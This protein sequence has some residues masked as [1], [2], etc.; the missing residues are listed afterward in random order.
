MNGWDEGGMRV[1]MAAG[2]MAM[3]GMQ[4][5]PRQVSVRV[6]QQHR[7]AHVSEWYRY[8]AQAVRVS[9][10]ATRE[11]VHTFSPLAEEDPAWTKLKQPSRWSQA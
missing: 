4:N 6:D 10:E 5:I 1:G 8:M 11:C 7:P 9:I 3:A 2:R